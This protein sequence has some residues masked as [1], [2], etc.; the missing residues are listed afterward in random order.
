[1]MSDNAK[2]EINTKLSD[3]GLTQ[4][5]YSDGIKQLTENRDV[6]SLFFIAFSYYFYFI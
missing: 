3:F 6:Q 5:L 4:F 1:M 2:D